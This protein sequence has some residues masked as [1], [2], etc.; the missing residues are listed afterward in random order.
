MALL[1][2]VAFLALL[3]R[4]TH[5]TS[6]AK[7]DPGPE[8]EVE[9]VAGDAQQEALFSGRRVEPRKSPRSKRTRSREL[10]GKVFPDRSF[11]A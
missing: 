6:V 10:K 4:E 8:F 11:W 9:G 1:V 5:Q 2:V 7:K 3:P